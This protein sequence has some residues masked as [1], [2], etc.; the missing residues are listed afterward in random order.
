M[1]NTSHRLLPVLGRAAG[2]AVPE[3][4]NTSRDLDAVVGIC[5]EGD[6]DMARLGWYTL[7]LH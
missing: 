3:R 1:E 5:G 6:E 7:C 4:N 2:S